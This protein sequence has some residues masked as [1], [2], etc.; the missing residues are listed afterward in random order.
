MK[1]NN[2]NKDKYE[3]AKA[4]VTRV[5][6]FY[7]HLLAYILVICILTWNLT[8]IDDAELKDTFIVVNG[9]SITLWGI[10]IIIHGWIAFK[11][12]FLFSKKWE[13]R[14]VKEYLQE[15]EEEIE[16]WE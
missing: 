11:G 3:K 1:T 13:E 9:S 5:K 16:V 8:V 12:R 4:K 2:I 6:M 15:D 7:Y 10:A 14:K